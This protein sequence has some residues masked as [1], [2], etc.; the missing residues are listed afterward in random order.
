MFRS[1]CPGIVNTGTD[2]VNRC[3]LAELK[4]EGQ[5]QIDEASLD[6]LLC[7][8]ARLL[9]RHLHHDLCQLCGCLAF[10]YLGQ[11][12]G[13]VLLIY[14][15][16]EFVHLRSWFLLGRLAVQQLLRKLVAIVLPAASA[17]IMIQSR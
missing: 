12:A 6:D 13:D 5:N 9:L 11:I 7:G 4:G 17:I 8:E 3:T 16:G 1:A 10:A 2:V 15:D 14:I